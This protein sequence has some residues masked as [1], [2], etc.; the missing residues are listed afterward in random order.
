MTKGVYIRTEKH[1]RN[2]SLAWNYDK[3]FTQQTRENIS[4]SQEIEGVDY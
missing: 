3:H 1:K 2:L 4:K